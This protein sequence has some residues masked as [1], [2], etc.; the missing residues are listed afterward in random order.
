MTDNNDVPVEIKRALLTQE[1][2]QWKNTAY[3]LQ[4]RHRVN[5]KLGAEEQ[6]LKSLEDE[7]VKAENAIDILSE[8]LK[9]LG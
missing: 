6:A 2:G 4:V 5:K 9:A 8:E 3:L 1:I 7:M